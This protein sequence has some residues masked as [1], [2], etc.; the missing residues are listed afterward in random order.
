MTAVANEIVARAGNES[1]GPTVADGSQNICP[2]ILRVT[3]HEEQ[4]A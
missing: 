3:S 4:R 1:R 2:D